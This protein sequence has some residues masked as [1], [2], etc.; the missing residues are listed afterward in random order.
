MDRLATALRDFYSSRRRAERYRTPILP[1]AQESYELSVK[2]Y[3]GGQFEY[4]RVLE[5]R[6]SVTQASLEAIRALGEAWKAAGVSS[7]LTREEQWPPV[8][9]PTKETK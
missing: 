3:K 7:G 8:F 5:A 1:K 9:A 4:L 2:A 6:R